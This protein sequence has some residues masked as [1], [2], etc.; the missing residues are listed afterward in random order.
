[1]Q[2][3]GQL[4]KKRKNYKTEITIDIIHVDDRI[5]DVYILDNNEHNLEDTLKNIN[6]NVVSK[7]IFERE[8]AYP[9]GTS[10]YSL[11]FIIDKNM[12]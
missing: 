7:P 8:D 3:F 1:M 5:D 2:I 11:K 4:S 6:I 12:N 9:D 10:Y